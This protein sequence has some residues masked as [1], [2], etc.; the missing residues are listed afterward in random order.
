MLKEF[1]CYDKKTCTA[2]YFCAICGVKMCLHTICRKTRYDWPYH[3]YCGSC[4]Y[5]IDLLEKIS[6]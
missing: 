5:A 1:L 2:R 4:Y 6:A 3:T